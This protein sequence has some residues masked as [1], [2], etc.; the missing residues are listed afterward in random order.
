LYFY[1]IFVCREAREQHSS[2]PHPR[3]FRPPK[4]LFE[5]NYYFDMVDWEKDAKTEPPLT[6]DLSEKELLDVIATPLKL[7]HYPCHT[8]HVERVVPVVA[9]AALHCVGFLNRNRFVTV[10]TLYGSVVVQ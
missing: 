9:E 7:P 5:A 10:L 3:Q 1:Y 6:Q 8:Q 2:I 4:L